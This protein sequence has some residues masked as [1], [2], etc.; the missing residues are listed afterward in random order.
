MYLSALLTA[1]LGFTIV[2]EP[3]QAAQTPGVLHASVTSLIVNAIAYATVAAG[4][5]LLG[6]RIGAGS[7]IARFLTYLV[8]TTLTLCC[9]SLN[10]FRLL[11]QIVPSDLTGGEEALTAFSPPVPHWYDVATT[12]LTLAVVA[13]LV[14]VIV[15]L[16]VPAA[17]QYFRTQPHTP[18]SPC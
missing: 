11:G 3:L 14:A 5:T 4:L 8:A 2:A 17:N 18:R 16:S 12:A 6:I 9:G 7:D 15:L 1:L 10:L 13:L